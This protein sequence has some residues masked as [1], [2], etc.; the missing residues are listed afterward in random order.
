M[1]NIHENIICKNK[2]HTIKPYAFEVLESSSEGLLLWCRDCLG[3]GLFA[4]EEGLRLLC[5]GGGS[6]E[7]E[8]ELRWCLLCLP[9]FV[10]GNCAD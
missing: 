2:E 8:L 6:L 7:S 1:S 3:G 10:R 4:S 5:L 9:D